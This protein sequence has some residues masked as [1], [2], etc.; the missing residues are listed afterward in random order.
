MSVQSL[1]QELESLIESADYTVAVFAGDNYLSLRIIY[2]PR[3]QVRG[4][5]GLAYI[6][7]GVIAEHCWIMRSSKR[8]WRKARK[9]VAAEVAGHREFLQMARQA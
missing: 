6:A 2:L 9:W 5:G 1:E 8:R 3:L 4:Q 7:N